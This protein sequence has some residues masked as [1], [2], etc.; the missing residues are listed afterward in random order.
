MK[1]YVDS[2]GIMYMLLKKYLYG[3][4]QAASHFANHLNCTLKKMN[5]KQAR[6]D[7]CLHIRSG[8]VRGSI[9]AAGT[10]VDDIIVT[11]SKKDIDIF[12]VELKK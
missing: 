6:V 1:P 4:P 7:S 10:W 5:M 12:E 2:Q 9:V 11:G 3:L 8:E